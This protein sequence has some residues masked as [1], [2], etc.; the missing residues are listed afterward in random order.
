[1]KKALI[2]HGTQG[3]PQGNWFAWLQEHLM[4]QGWQVAV[5][6]LPTPE[7]QSLENWTVALEEQVPS[8]AEADLIIGH[9]CGGAFAL[10]LLEGNIITPEQT[11]LVGTVIDTLGNQFDALNKSF[12]DTPFNWDSIKENCEDITVFHGDNDPYVPL[13][14]AETLSENLQAPLYVIQNGGHINADAGYT[15]FPDLLDFIND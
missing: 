1:M 14:Q 13:S 8:F 7:D 6:T 2:F 12:V 4:I 15:E 9:S 10:R 11:I 3:T 5:P